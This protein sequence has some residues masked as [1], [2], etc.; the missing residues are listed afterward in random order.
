MQQA[1]D[2]TK[3]GALQASRNLTLTLTLIQT[4]NL[5]LILTLTIFPTILPCR[6]SCSTRKRFS[7]SKPLARRVCLGEC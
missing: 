4:F 7:S 3:M 1:I 2:T 5:T 6:T